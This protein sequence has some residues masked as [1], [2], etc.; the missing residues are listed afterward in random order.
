MSDIEI[1]VVENGFSVEYCDPEIRAAND[2]VT[3]GKSNPWKDPKKEFVFT[4]V[5]EVI[6]FISTLLPKLQPSDDEGTEF[7]KAFK[8]AS[9]EEK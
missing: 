7:S 1:E 5:P 4:T 6:S 2:K 8:V 9:T 3:I